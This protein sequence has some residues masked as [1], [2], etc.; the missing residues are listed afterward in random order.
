MYYRIKSDLLL[1]YVNHYCG[2]KSLSE[3]STLEENIIMSLEFD[4]LQQKFRLIHC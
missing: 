2:L 4:F 3:E 1:L